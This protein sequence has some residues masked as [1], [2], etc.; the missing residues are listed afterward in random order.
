M[1]SLGRNLPIR[2]AEWIRYKWNKWWLIAATLWKCDFSRCF[3]DLC[4]DFTGW[5][6]CQEAAHRPPAGETLGSSGYILAK[7]KERSLEPH[8][9]AVQEQQCWARSLVRHKKGNTWKGEVTSTLLHCS[10]ESSVSTLLYSHGAWGPCTDRRAG[11][12]A[13]RTPYCKAG[14]NGLMCAV[15]TLPFQEDHKGLGYLRY[16][17]SLNYFWPCPCWPPFPATFQSIPTTEAANRNIYQ[18]FSFSSNRAENSAIF[19]GCVFHCPSSLMIHKCQFILHHY[20]EYNTNCIN[21]CFTLVYSCKLALSFPHLPLFL[22]YLCYL[23]SISKYNSFN[24]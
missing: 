2:L 4:K 15:P 21:P 8:Q 13:H 5:Q 23:G 22:S 3:H 19:S 10:P 14:W 11:A 6:Q 18:S 17:I 12:G 24:N 20:F 9:A 16:F 1:R 7:C